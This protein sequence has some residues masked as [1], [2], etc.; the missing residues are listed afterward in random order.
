MLKADLLRWRTPPVILSYGMAVLSVTVALI[1]ARWLELYFETAPAALFLCAVMFSAWFGGIRPGLL[2]AVLCALAFEYYFMLPF[3]SF[4]LEPKEIPRFIIFV[5]SAIFVGSLSAAQRRAAESLRHARNELQGTVKDL[6]RANAEL[7]RSEAF[8]AEGQRISH[9][10]NWSWHVL[11]GKIVCSEEHYRV[12]GFEPGEVEPTFSLFLEMLHSED[13]PVVEQI[14]D[15]SIRARSGFDYECRITLPDESIK[16]LQVVGRPVV[17][18]S[19]DVDEFTGTTMDITER[20][21]VEEAL[22][23]S[24]EQWRAVFEHNPTMYFMLDA[25]GTI[26][27]VNPFGA[28]QLGYTVDELVGHPVLTL[29]HEADREAIKGNVAICL[30][31]PGQTK[32]WEVRKLRKDGT[33]LWVRENVKVMPGA[34]NRP[35]LLVACEDITERRKAQDELRRSEALLAEGQRISRTGSWSWHLPTGKLVWSE[36][37]YRLLGFE[38]GEVEPTISLFLALLH[39]KDRPVVEQIVENAI[40]ARSDFNYEFCIDFPDGSIKYFQSVGHALVKP[41][42]DVDEYFGTTMDITERKEAEE[43]LRERESRIRRLVESNIIGILF[44]NLGGDVADAND[45]LLQM[46]GY[47][48]QELLSGNINWA[49]MTPREYRAADAHAIEELERTGT[50]IPY[51]KEFIRKDG[52]RVPILVGVALFE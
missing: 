44:W 5:L 41:F 2:A 40:R 45:A 46:V 27:S 22:R 18:L 29:F 42:G 26:L 6:T 3:H 34:N 17:K 37:Q 38:P 52:S 14:V 25:D 43:A 1:F 19:G 24:E 20:K 49:S 11:T 51:E 8:L 48:R 13:R 12:F 28:E 9:T 39:S 4:A 32:S 7:Q 36:E 47:S 16:Y 31:Q 35:I 21:E 15:N 33:V 23:K 10:G 30:E 50:C